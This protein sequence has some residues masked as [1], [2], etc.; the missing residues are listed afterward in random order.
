MLRSIKGRLLLWIFC[1]VSVLFC[2]FGWALH[3]KLHYLI[4]DSIDRTIHSSL[5]LVK[6]LV[7]THDGK[8]IQCES[9]EFVHGDYVVPDSGHYYKVFVDGELVG[10]SF[11]LVD[12]DFDLSPGEPI[13]HNAKA[14]EWVYETEGPN[15]E[16]LRVIRHDFVYMDKPIQV[17]AAENMA[18]SLDM[19]HR[20]TIFFMIVMPLVIFAIGLT[21]LAIASLSLRPLH[22]F[23]AALEK[24][25]HKNLEERIET[26]RQT[27]ELRRLAEK[28]NALLERLQQ[29]FEAEKNLLGNA[30]HELKT[31]LAVIRAECDIA[32][33]K[34]RSAEEHQES[35]QEIR[36]VSEA[37][38]DQVNGLL[39]LARLDSGML[40]ASAFQPVSLKDCIADAARLAEPLAKQKNVLLNASLNG[41]GLVVSGDKDTL[42]EAVLNVIENGVKYNHPGGFVAVELRRREDRAEIVVSDTGIGISEEDN[43]RIFDRFYRAASARSMEGSGLGLS[44]VKAVMQAHQ[45]EILAEEQSGGGSRFVLSLPLA[46]A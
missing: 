33:Q 15:G 38:L 9:N 18:E 36:S 43:A 12:K 10:Y 7:H 17:I 31:P 22:D 11:S 34:P 45:G 14:Q 13:F 27:V 2:A 40:D 21:S 39:T 16:P 37:M 5:Q 32:L 41:G 20:L 23:S 42:T 24:I 25:S 35:L 26:G 44:I 1:S 4:E 29:A 8:S 28:F 3:L 19:I 30:A 6:G 46:A